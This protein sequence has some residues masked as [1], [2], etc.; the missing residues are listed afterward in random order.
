MADQVDLTSAVL[1]SYRF[2]E[3]GRALFD[4]G[5]GRHSRDEDIYTVRLQDFPDTAPM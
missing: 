3:D 1:L 5:G 4:R 2:F